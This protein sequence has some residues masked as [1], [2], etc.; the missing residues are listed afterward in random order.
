MRRRLP[1]L[2]TIILLVSCTASGETTDGETPSTVESAATDV[3]Q[4]TVAADPTTPPGDDPCSLATPE[5]VAAAFGGTVA[6]GQPGIARNCTYQITGGIDDSVDVYHYGTADSWDGVR[7]GFEDNRGGTTD[8]PGLGD[9]AFH[10]NDMGPMELVVSAGGV[11]FSVGGNM[12]GPGGAE[13]EAAVLALAEA[14][15]AA[16]G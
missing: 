13:I 4:T 10:P 6:P 1:T 3:P 15:A 2:M 9:E 8:V 7:Q 14:I 12:F 16:Q 11:I 5:M